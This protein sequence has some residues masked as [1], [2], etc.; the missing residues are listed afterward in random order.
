VSKLA[1]ST[2]VARN[3]GALKGIR[4]HFTRR[5]SVVLWGVTY[6]VE[7]LAAVFE[8]HLA[9]MARVEELTLQRAAAVAHERQLEARLRPVHAAIKDL[10]ESELGIHSIRMNDYGIK[11]DRK[12]HMTAETKKRANEKRQATRAQRGI[13]GKRRRARMK[14][15]G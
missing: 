12:P 7:A 9:A 14:R 10:A 11:P 3:L 2:K 8:D 15:Q 1:K 6:T 5:K 4:K 13:I